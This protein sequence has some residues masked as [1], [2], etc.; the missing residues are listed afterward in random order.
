MP[1]HIEAESI[2]NALA[3]TGSTMQ[4]MLLD[5][6]ELC[7]TKP[8]TRNILRYMIHCYRHPIH[9]IIIGE[10][11]YADHIIP[12]MGSAYGQVIDSD[13]TPSMEVICKHFTDY[14]GMRSTIRDSWKLLPLGY[15]FVNAYYSSK[16]ANDVLL[17]ERIERVIEYICD[18]YE[19]RLSLDSSTSFTLVSVGSVAKY[20]ISEVSSRMRAHR[21]SHKRIHVIQPAALYKYIHLND[22]IGVHDD[23]TC[24][25]ASGMRLFKDTCQGHTNHKA[26]TESD[27]KMATS[28]GV[29]QMLSSGIK[30]IAISNEEVSK[31]L[32]VVRR[33]TDINSKIDGVISAQEKTNVM[34]QELLTL[35]HSN[36]FLTSV[37][38]DYVV[39]NANQTTAVNT[40]GVVPTTV[41][42]ATSVGIMTG[43]NVQATQSEFDTSSQM[44]V[45]VSD[46]FTP[47]KTS[48]VK[49]IK[50]DDSN[51]SLDNVTVPTPKFNT[52]N[53]PEIDTSGD[54]MA[55][56]TTS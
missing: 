47:T 45:S 13:D 39:P 22:K 52:P 12:Y 49:S 43:T 33:D 20:S 7:I 31:A 2:P 35:L 30:G 3:R 40:I 46:M 36:A 55:G 51:V 50:E 8:S 56:I 24:F 54:P 25:T 29:S 23:Y 18:V 17:I 19:H 10:R 14:S 42:S 37:I 34:I 11:P 53:K 9:T 4:S 27:F 1:N 44:T 16:P 28:S 26:V 48:A 38:M 5:I 32:A 41:M 15:M 21:I 6:E